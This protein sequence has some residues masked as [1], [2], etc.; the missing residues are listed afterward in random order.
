MEIRSLK[1][2]HTLGRLIQLEVT[3]RVEKK[4]E[5][6]IPEDRKI[7]SFIDFDSIP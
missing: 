3:S 7:A 5:E 1:M 4:T 2:N 6:G